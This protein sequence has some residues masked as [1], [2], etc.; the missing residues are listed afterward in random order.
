M[1]ARAAD[2][3]QAAAARSE[4]LALV[5]DFRAAGLGL[6]PL[7]LEL[8]RASAEALSALAL[9]PAEGRELLELALGLEDRLAF[10]ERPPRGLVL[11]L[12]QC[13]RVLPGLPLRTGL[14]PGALE[15][16]LARALDALRAL[17][18]EDERDAFGCVLARLRLE[19][20]LASAGES[21]ELSS[22][23]ANL[24]EFGSDPKGAAE[25]AGLLCDAARRAER[26]TVAW[27]ALE[28]LERA[29]PQLAGESSRILR[30]WSASLRCQ[31]ELASGLVERA[32]FALAEERALVAQGGELPLER[33]ALL[34]D[35]TSV[36]LAQVTPRPMES[37]AVE[38]EAAL[39]DGE[40]A[41]VFP[42]EHAALASRLALLRGLGEELGGPAATPALETAA[43]LPALDPTHRASLALFLFNRGLQRDDA[44]L[45][46]RALERLARLGDAATLAPELAAA[47]SAAAA[48][49]A[50]R[51]GSAD[52][53]ERCATELELQCQRRLE[54]LA[55]RP[56]R[57]GGFGYLAYQHR[58]L[59]DEARVRLALLRGGPRAALE[60]L[61]PEQL[62][63]SLA[64]RIGA[65]AASVEALT[66]ELL[67]P[68]RALL[69][70]AAGAD[71]VHAFLLEGTEVLHAA[72]PWEYRLETLP[73]QLAELLST[74]PTPLAPSERARRLAQLE[75][76]ARLL[77]AR[78]L[79]EPFTARLAKLEELYVSGA[80][81]L[82][83]P[84]ELLP[85]GSEPLGLRL[86][87]AHLPSLPVGL[88]LARSAREDTAARPFSVQL[89]AAPQP[90]PELEGEPARLAP[91]RLAPG[92]LR[93]LRGPGSDAPLLGEAA[94]PEA[95]FAALG[96]QRTSFLHVLVHGHANHRRELPAALVLAPDTRHADG[97]LWNDELV[98]RPFVSAPCVALSACS[99]AL[100][101]RR[102]GDD[103]A[104]QLGG[105]FLARGA[106]VTL[107]ATQE[108]ALEPTVLLMSAFTDELER[109]TTPAR[110]LLA[111]RRAL[112]RE[113]AFA[114]PFFL[115]A[116]RLDGLGH[117]PLHARPQ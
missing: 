4:L 61:L 69:V 50:L 64:R 12:A 73:R 76:H 35:V 110:A 72:L 54:A 84:L 106:R 39:V 32:S 43:D 58:R 5:A 104:A 30:R 88:A 40:L 114:H 19:E 1:L 68:G 29:A 83:V 49:H 92:D 36:A 86:A 14:A 42:V 108:L 53:L 100:G 79:P 25:L 87:L 11:A 99:S 55:A 28:C 56:E 102:I 111:A 18:R 77:A 96:R 62:L 112:A 63:G 15:A 105:T 22:S 51:S 20:L 16:H 59:V 47:R 52:E 7:D 6:E 44:A 103:G 91:L 10:E 21:A 93:R 9:Q 46:A 81:L 8:A 116:L 48:L 65:P 24:A 66:R 71:H 94:T 80:G 107:L 26:W 98:S 78:L 2:P 70:F 75:E 95:L 90:A 3:R 85:L 115:F 113:P 27:S 101:P 23:A 57:A 67:A 17:P 117:A 33:L 38:L 45:R 60:A 74:S 31:L 109:G 37:A 97:L 89:V 41:R 82:D 13:W 34:L